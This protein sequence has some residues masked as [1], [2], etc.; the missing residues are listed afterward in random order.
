MYTEPSIN[1]SNY[2]Y[3]NYCVLAL[4]FWAV[5]SL[6]CCTGAF[7]SCSGQELLFLMVHGLSHCSVFSCCG[8][9]ALECMGFSSRGSQALSAGSVVM[10]HEHSCPAACGILQDQGSN[11][12]PLHWG[13]RLLTT[14]PPGKSQQLL[15]VFLGEPTSQY[16]NLHVYLSPSPDCNFG[17]CLAP[18]AL[19]CAW[20]IWCAPFLNES[21]HF[22]GRMHWGKGG[23]CCL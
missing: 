18:L 17:T 8:A 9:P 23:E 4:L 6:G 3:Y 12:C 11:L 19:L 16:W 22:S 20:N 1:I 14:G 13:S 15:T 10:V 21:G 7:S 5:L 2:P